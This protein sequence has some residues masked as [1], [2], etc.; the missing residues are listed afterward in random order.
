MAAIIAQLT[1]ANRERKKRSLKYIQNTKCTYTLHPFHPNGFNPA[2]HNK[3]IMER[4]RHRVMC[5]QNQEE[6]RVVQDIYKAYMVSGQYLGEAYKIR[7]QGF[8][9]RIRQCPQVQR[10]VPLTC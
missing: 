1:L 2:V 8:Q 5:L 9:R 7:S 10:N 4:E 3:Y 6:E